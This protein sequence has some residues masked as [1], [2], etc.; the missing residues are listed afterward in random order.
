MNAATKKKMGFHDGVSYCVQITK[1]GNLYFPRITILFE[2]PE[3][4]DSCEIAW[5]FGVSAFDKN[6]YSMADGI[7]I[8][9]IDARAMTGSSSIE[10]IELRLSQEKE[11]ISKYKKDRSAMVPLTE[12]FKQRTAVAA[13]NVKLLNCIIKNHYMSERYAGRTSTDY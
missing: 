7:A 5:L 11:V 12:E 2:N 6:P 1:V 3:I 4:I 9:S 8:G 13:K 10:R